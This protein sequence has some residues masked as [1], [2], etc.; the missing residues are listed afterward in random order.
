MAPLCQVVHRDVKLDNILL[1]AGTPFGPASVPLKL[2]FPTWSTSPSKSRA[3]S[4]LWRR[5][6]DCA[7]TLRVK[8]FDFGFSTRYKDGVRL[9][10]WCA[11]AM[12][13][14]P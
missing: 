11:A 10:E 8:V 5:C 6:V 2:P 13:A 3:G 7:G 12:R 9:S 14:P 4:P 1:E